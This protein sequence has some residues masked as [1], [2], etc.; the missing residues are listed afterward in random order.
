M[1]F[2]PEEESYS[3]PQPEGLSSTSKVLLVLTGVFGL[4]AL[5]CCGGVYYFVNQVKMEESSDPADVIATQKSILPATIP[6]RFEPAQSV[7]MNI[8]VAEIEMAMYQAKASE[9]TQVAFM[10]MSFPMG[11]M[12]QAQAEAQ[13]SQQDLIDMELENETQEEKIYQ[14]DGREL[15]VVISHGTPSENGSPMPQNLPEAKT[16]AS[17]APEETETPESETPEPEGTE[18]VEAATEGEAEESSAPKWFAV[19]M[20]LMDDDGMLIFSM[21]GPE[22]EFDQA[23]IDALINSFKFSGD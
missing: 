23:E 21:Q 16:V 4:A 19:R 7:S 17:E 14:V 6:D 18:E 15:T 1:S 3:D 10:R 20:T 8:V 2:S 22:D 11:G 9:Q 13:L 5:A 12:N